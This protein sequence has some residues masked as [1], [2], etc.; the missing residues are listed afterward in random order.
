[1]LPTN[2][3]NQSLLLNKLKNRNKA[4]KIFFFSVFC[5]YLLLI[6]LI[7]HRKKN[8]AKKKETEITSI[9]LISY[10]LPMPVLLLLSDML[11]LKEDF[12]DRISIHHFDS[13][14]DR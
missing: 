9:G 2:T 13:P 14:T 3:V 7:L 8:V 12:F 1:M 11:P 10:F 4:K 5:S 6:P